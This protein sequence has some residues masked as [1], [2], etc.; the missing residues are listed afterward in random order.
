MEAIEAIRREA[1]LRRDRAISAARKEYRTTL[2]RI[3]QLESTFK[4]QGQKHERPETQAAIVA[5]CL[6]QDRLFAFAEL[7]AIVE[8]AAPEREFCEPG[9]RAAFHVLAKQG[10]V[11]RVMR[12]GDRRVL[13][14]V[15]D[16]NAPESPYGAKSFPKV[17]IELLRETGPLDVTHIVVALQSR[18]YR[19]GYDPHKLHVAVRSCLNKRRQWFERDEA[20]RWGVIE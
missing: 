4:V 15:Q 19:P 17:L 12:D 6:P 13:Y 18:G 20:G 1:R 5:R 9:V 10:A 3:R 14:C 2:A 16:Y 7:F 8:C 11:R